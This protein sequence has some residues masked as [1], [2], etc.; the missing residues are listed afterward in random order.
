M[1][2]GPVGRIDLK[3]VL[4]SK[5]VRDL[6]L[7]ILG[8]AIAALAVDMFMVPKGLAAG[9]VTGLFFRIVG[10]CNDYAALASE[11]TYCEA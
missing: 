10:R 5:F 3:R 1:A 6:P 9:G 2:V 11:M 4:K 7:V 8:C